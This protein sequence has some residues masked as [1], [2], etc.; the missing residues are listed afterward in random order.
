MFGENRK[1]VISRDAGSDYEHETH[2][3][4]E[5]TESSDGNRRSLSRE[6]ARR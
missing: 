2:P 1:E 4:I 6:M 5:D 3:V